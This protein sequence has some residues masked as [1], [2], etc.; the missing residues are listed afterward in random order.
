MIKINITTSPNPKI[1]FGS[2]KEWYWVYAYKNH[3]RIGVVGVREDGFF[4]DLFV[5]ED[6]R[7]K[8]VATR[9]LLKCEG[10]VPADL[11]F[12]HQ[13]DTPVVFYKKIG[14]KKRNGKLTRPNLLKKGD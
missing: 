2:D 10:L 12:Y 13:K 5:Q 4:H 7:N 6:Y 11:Y 14:F 3:K 1:Q 9:L 8:K